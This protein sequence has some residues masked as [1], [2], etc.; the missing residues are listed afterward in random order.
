LI[1]FDLETNKPKYDD[2]GL[3][4]AV[5][6]HY[7]N[8]NVLMVGY[9]N[10]ESLK[11]TVDTG[12]ATFFSRSR[13]QLWIKGETSGNFLLVKDIRIDCDSDA[14]LILAEP[15]G[16]T[17]HTGSYSCFGDAVPFNGY[18]INMLEETINSRKKLIDEGQDGGSSYTVKLLTAGVDRILRKIGEEASET[19]IA[20]KNNDRQELVYE[21]SDLI[22]HLM[23]LLANEGIPFDEITNEL[24]SRHGKQH[25]LPKTS[26]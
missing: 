4:T 23:V 9:M 6:Q 17:C 10:E 18:I 26:V 1:N 15:I 7:A 22:F 11:L 20:A 25:G 12:K 19:I 14:L 8:G 24:N 3:V 5:I 2:K 13:N 21:S 16:P